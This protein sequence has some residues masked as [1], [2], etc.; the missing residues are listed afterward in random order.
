[1][2]QGSSRPSSPLEY[3]IFYSTH[4]KRR[5]V[6]ALCEAQFILTGIFLC[7]DIPTEKYILHIAI[8]LPGVI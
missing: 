8:T 4:C 3:F 1:M 2:K 7:F 6:L 5:E